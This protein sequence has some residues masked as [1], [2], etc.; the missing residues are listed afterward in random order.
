MKF[1]TTRIQHIPLATLDTVSIVF[2]SMSSA[3]LVI[4]YYIPGG[5]TRLAM[6]NRGNVEIGMP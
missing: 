4:L 3:L 6:A 1:L 5:S 2:D